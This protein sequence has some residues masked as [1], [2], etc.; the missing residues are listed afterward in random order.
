MMCIPIDASSEK[1]ATMP[2]VFKESNTD[3]ISGCVGVGVGGGGLNSSID[4]VT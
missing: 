4:V 3:R 1:Y 2:L